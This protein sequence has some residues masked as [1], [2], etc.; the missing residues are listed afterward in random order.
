MVEAYFILHVYGEYWSILV[1]RVLE[2]RT[3]LTDEILPVLAVPAAQNAEILEAQG[4]STVVPNPEM[5]Q[6]RKYPQ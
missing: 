5:L 1:L 3:L 6:A 2:V 4:V